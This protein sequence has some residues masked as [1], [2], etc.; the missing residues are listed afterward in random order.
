MK[1][2][3]WSLLRYIEEQ[4]T[5]NSELLDSL[6]YDLDRH[7]NFYGRQFRW[8]YERHSVIES[9]KSDARFLRHAATSLL[10]SGYCSASGRDKRTIVSNAYFGV[11]MDLSQ[12]GYRVLTPAWS[13]RNSAFPMCGS[14][15]LRCAVSRC[16][17]ILKTG[18]FKKI[19]SR[20]FVKQIN[21]VAGMLEEN[22]RALDAAA[23]VVPNDMS[24]FENL[25]IRIF[26][27]LKRPSFVFLHGLPSRY[28]TLDDNR[29][30]H[31]VVW[32]EAIKRR[33]IAAGVDARKIH[34]SGHPLYRRAPVGELRCRLDDVLVLTKSMNGGNYGTDVV[35][36]NR[37]NCVLYLVMLQD[38][39]KQCGVSAARFRVHPS[40]DVG[41]Y[42]QFIDKEFWVEDT[43]DVQSSL[44][45]AS[46]VIGPTSTMFLESLWH[47]VN[48]MIFE[49]LRD[50]ATLDNY[51]LVPPFDG[52]DPRVPVAH[53]A[54]TLVRML[55]A[56]EKPDISF[57]SD[58]I[59][60]GFDISFMAALL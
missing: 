19:I 57:W 59:R 28:N 12:C 33:Y 23:L 27:K 5:L 40:E 11:N 38:I 36:T 48:Y 10:F 17:H 43:G 51:P 39:L 4:G 3:E 52:S 35:H 29:A 1:K 9:L 44:S 46:L 47:G 7:I 26:K 37:G 21:D 49:P 56:G 13:T 58:Y 32:G 25:S 18:P 22:Y 2:H 24:F 14:R 20:Q 16:D 54:A 30:D 60:D 34:V 8:P 41:W 45:R 6:R 55:T 42:R 50:G 31:L 53:D 15:S